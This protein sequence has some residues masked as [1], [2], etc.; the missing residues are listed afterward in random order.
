MHYLP[1][2]PA[3]L[4]LLALAAG[5][6]ADGPQPPPKVALR[7][8]L[9]GMQRPVQILTDGSD[10]LFILEQVGKVRVLRAGNLERT[11]FL[12]LSDKVFVEY[13]C[14][15]LGLAFHPKFAENGLV[16]VNYTA[17]APQLRTFISEFR[18]PDPR[19]GAVDPASERVVLAIDQP[20]PNH[21]GGHLE[22]GPDGMLYIGMGDG[23]DGHDPQNFGQRTDALLGKFL[24]I[25]VTPRQGYAVPKDN[26]FVGDARYRPE[27]WALGVRNPWRFAF[28]PP[29][30]L[31]YMADVGQ[32][33]WE[34]VNVIE[35]GGNYGWR[36]R[37]GARDLHPVK[38]PPR[39]LIDPIFEY[40]HGDNAA[41]ITGGLV[42]RGKSMP[43][44]EGHYVFADYVLGRIWALKYDP[45][46]KKVISS[47]VIH[48]PDPSAPVNANPWKRPTQPSC[49]GVDAEGN[50]YMAEQSKG[51][52]FRLVPDA[53]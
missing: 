1:N 18:A 9:K 48:E 19:A 51:M 4:T 20:Y 24:R 44:L 29:T 7:P 43:G 52:V 33:L 8:V 21:N 27:I 14:G 22:F 42:Y 6:L 38:D 40:P 13:E 26:P 50:L 17:K 15:L 3:L 30:G 34:E 46:A 28:D 37:E 45:R 12:N 31:L 32:D 16:Y 53:Q 36:I 23:G 25:D 11:P 39:G 49:F 2:L 47:G 10:R 5:A 41:S 35:R